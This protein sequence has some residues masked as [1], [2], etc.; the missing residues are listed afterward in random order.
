METY[1]IGC[2]YSTLKEAE[3]GAKPRE[4]L[5][6]LGIGA[7]TDKELLML[8]IGSGNAKRPVDGIA[9]DLLRK[10]DLMPMISTE[11]IML[12]PGMGRA[13]ASAIAAAM[14]LGRRRSHRKPRI[15]TTPE[16]VY[17]EVSHYA[18]REQEHL[19]VVLLNGAHEIIGTFVATIGLLNKTIVHPREVFVEAIRM[20]AAAIAIAHNHPSGNIDPSEEDKDVTK[21][22]LLSGKILGIKLLDHI[23]FTDEK[24]YSFLEHGLM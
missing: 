1:R 13:K 17:R 16:D 8:I 24:Y 6:R 21:R 7:L 11:E 14:E 9:E 3:N 12:I 22:L 5:E 2:G 18:S 20:R 23:V 19:I 4:K 10:L 15:V